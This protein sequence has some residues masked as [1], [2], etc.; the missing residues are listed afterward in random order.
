MDVSDN[1][2]AAFYKEGWILKMFYRGEKSDGILCVLNIE[3]ILT[4]TEMKSRNKY[5]HVMGL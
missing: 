1:S 3:E 5:K 2:K 4:T